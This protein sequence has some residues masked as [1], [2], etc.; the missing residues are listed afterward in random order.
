MHHFKKFRKYTFKEEESIW[1]KYVAD[2]ELEEKNINLKRYVQKKLDSFDSLSSLLEENINT[3]C[4][5]E[6]EKYDKK[7]HIKSDQLTYYDKRLKFIVETEEKINELDA[8]LL[9]DIELR[10]SQW[11]PDETGEK[12]NNFLFLYS[13]LQE[14]NIIE[15][16]I[17]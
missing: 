2:A 9:K 14:H 11:K 16:K 17:I 4:K 3:E 8:H 15:K 10:V 13:L 6:L 7:I 5:I 1:K 12:L